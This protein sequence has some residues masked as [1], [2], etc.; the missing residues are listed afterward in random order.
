MIIDQDG[1]QGL[2]WEG[3]LDLKGPESKQRA[4]SQQPVWQPGDLPASLG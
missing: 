4:R 3:G 2:L 1:E